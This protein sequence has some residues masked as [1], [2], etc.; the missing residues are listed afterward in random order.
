MIGFITH[1]LLSLA[2]IDPWMARHPPR[3]AVCALAATTL[4]A[5]VWAHDH[6]VFMI[7]FT[8][9]VL[10]I[11]ERLLRITALTISQNFVYQGFGLI[12]EA[13][14]VWELEQRF[15]ARWPLL[16]WGHVAWHV[17]SALACDRSLV[18]ISLARCGHTVRLRPRQKTS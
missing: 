16:A 4:V 7:G 2:P 13:R 9:L 17:L 14:F 6:E 1:A 5:Y 8:L 15:C 11:Q 12:V 3:A 18:A 10:L